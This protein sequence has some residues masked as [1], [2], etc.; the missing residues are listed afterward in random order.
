MG[1]GTLL[2][3]GRRVVKRLLLLLLLLWPL[4]LILLGASSP[5]LRSKLVLVLPEGVV[6]G[7]WIR[8]SSSGSDEFNHLSPFRKVDSLFLVLIVGRREWA[9]ND[10]I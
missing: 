8:K 9:S 2:Y 4:L 10:F 6:E 1:T 5:G 3:A 7:P